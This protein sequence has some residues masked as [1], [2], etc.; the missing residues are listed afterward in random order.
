MIVMCSICE[1]NATC[2]QNFCFGNLMHKMERKYQ[3]EGEH[4]LSGFIICTVYQMVL[5]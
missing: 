5:S 2:A 4:C 3:E 1:G